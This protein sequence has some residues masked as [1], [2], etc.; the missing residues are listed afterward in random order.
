MSN[1]S[2]FNFKI[3]PETN[4]IDDDIDMVANWKPKQNK[5]WVGFIH[6]SNWKKEQENEQKESNQASESYWYNPFS[7]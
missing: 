6:F 2:S 7:W 4:K 5:S 3:S 1:F